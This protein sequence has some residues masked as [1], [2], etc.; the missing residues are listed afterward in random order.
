MVLSC[1][2]MRRCILYH[3]PFLLDLISF[4]HLLTFTPSEGWEDKNSPAVS[5]GGQSLYGYQ[6]NPQSMIYDYEP[7]S[8]NLDEP[9]V[10]S[11]LPLIVLAQQ[12]GYGSEGLSVAPETPY[13]RLSTI[14][15]RTERTEPSPYWRSR[16]YLAPPDT[17][18]DI[19]SPETSYGQVIGQ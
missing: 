3:P 18:R 5:Q 10:R 4:W 11:R 17:S 2:L 7:N 14:T 16:Q 19:S 1:L 6:H 13:G 8:D 15:E 12:Q 9:E